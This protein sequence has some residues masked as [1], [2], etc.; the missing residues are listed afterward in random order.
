[1]VSQQSNQYLVDEVVVSMQSSADS[2]L[3]FGGDASLDHVLSHHIQPMVEEVV[4]L[5]KSLVDPTLLLESEKSKEVTLS[6]K[7]LANSTLLL[8]VMHISTMSL[9]FPVQYLLNKGAFHSLRICSL[10]VLGW[11]PLIGMIL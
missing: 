4:M 7:S 8:G 6:M 10:Q 5:M 11:F 9:A 1:L 2:T 3:V